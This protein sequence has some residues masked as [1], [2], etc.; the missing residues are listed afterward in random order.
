MMDNNDQTKELSPAQTSALAVVAVA[1][2]TI[3]AVMTHHTIKRVSNWR[4]E[5]RMDR[6][7]KEYNKIWDEYKY[8][9]G[10]QSAE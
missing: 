1:A 9:Q 8:Y 7:Q 2:G 3:A 10:E 5:R 6:I 4:E